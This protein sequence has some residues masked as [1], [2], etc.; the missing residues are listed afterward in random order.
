[1]GFSPF[2]E[3]TDVTAASSGMGLSA[4]SG[5][6]GHRPVIAVRNT[7]AMATLRCEEAV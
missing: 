1:M 6:S 2:S 7:P 5:L 4:S 3:W